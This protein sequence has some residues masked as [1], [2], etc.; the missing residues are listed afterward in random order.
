MFDSSMRGSQ[1]SC[2]QSAFTALCTKFMFPD[3]FHTTCAERFSKM[4]SDEEL[5]NQQG[6][7]TIKIAVS[8]AQNQL[9]VRAGPQGEWSE[10][11]WVK[12]RVWAEAQ[13]RARIA[14]KRRV[15]V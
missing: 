10:A 14:R 2:T 4:L 1:E 12:L 11:G 9:G 7:I 15:S 13:K 6:C 8:N 3:S 5:Y